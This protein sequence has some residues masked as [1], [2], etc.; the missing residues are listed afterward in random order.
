MFLMLYVSQAFALSG[1]DFQ[2]IGNRYGV[3]PHL[4]RAVSIIE[5]QDGKLTG[6]YEVRLV[7]DS[8]QLKFLKKIAR[9]TGRSLSDFK[10]SYAGAMG[11]MQIMPSTFYKYAQ[12]GDGDGVKDPLNQY[13]SLATAAYF[14]ARKIAKYGT[15]T[16]I[17]SYNN[18][19]IYCQKI[20]R[21]YWRF[22]LE[23]RIAS[24]QI[25]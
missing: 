6:N 24:R 15:R 13:D 10:G 22:E 25:E 18:S 23:A 14:L 3:S 2:I 7:V 12:D 1:L 17:R 5:S 8:I 11:H 19:S 20:L 16:A 4:L 9:A 21:L